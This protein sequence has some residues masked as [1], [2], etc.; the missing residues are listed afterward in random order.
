MRRQWMIWRC[1][2]LQEIATPVGLTR[3]GWLAMTAKVRMTTRH[4][5]SETAFAA[6]LLRCFIEG[7]LSTPR[8][9]DIK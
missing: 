8:Y 4:G 7:E 5:P 3:V 1:H 2:K 9:H 6:T